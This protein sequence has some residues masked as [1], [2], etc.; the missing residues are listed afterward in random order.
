MNRGSRGASLFRWPRERASESGAKEC[1]IMYYLIFNFGSF[2]P[3]DARVLCRC[4]REL[5]NENLFARC[6]FDIAENALCKVCPSGARESC[7][8]RT[9]HSPGYGGS[10]FLDYRGGADL[11]GSQ[12]LD[13][14][15]AAKAPGGDLANF[16]QIF[17]RFRLYRHR[18]LQVN[19]RFSVFFKIYQI[20]WLKIL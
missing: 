14:R 8:R 12:F 2:L 19:T 17:A 6:A 3:K 20:I 16:G 18:S 1:I 13:Y 15:G 5:S 11:G 10:Q 9:V 7:V 4:R